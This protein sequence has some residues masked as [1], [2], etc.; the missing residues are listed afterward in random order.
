M[1]QALTLF[2]KRWTVFQRIYIPYGAA[3]LI[4][5]IAAGLVTLFLK[6]FKA[7]GCSPT[8]SFSPSD[9]KSLSSQV[10]YDI[11]IGPA[12]KLSPN[13]LARIEATLPATG[14]G[15]SGTSTLSSSIHPID[16]TL[17]DFNKYIN[18]F[19][20]NVTPGGF[21]LG[22]DSSPPTFAYKGNGDISLATITQN[23]LDTLLLNVSISSQYQAFDTPWISGAGKTLQLVVYFGLAMAAYPAFFALYPTL[24]RLRNVRQLHYS[25][26]VRS[27][28]LWYVY[29]PEDSESSTVP[30][31]RL[32]R[33]FQVPFNISLPI[34]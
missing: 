8:S 31:T 7:P 30:Y 9:I 33:V 27:I 15:G 28:C 6:G 26:G 20:G 14:A 3:L 34:R 10:N 23:A 29:N 13:D 25:N 12:S 5:V 11:V 1:R 2:R 22:D 19:Y 21:F 17:D 16:G 18:T 32:Q 24:E 4:P